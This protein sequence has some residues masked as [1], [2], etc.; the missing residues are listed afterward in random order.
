MWPWRRRRE[1]PVGER[2]TKHLDVASG[3]SFR[4]LCAKAPAVKCKSV[5]CSKSTFLNGSIWASLQ[6]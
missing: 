2:V 4:L 1:N 5:W 6:L 3:A